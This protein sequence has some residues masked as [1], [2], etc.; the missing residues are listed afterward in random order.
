MFLSSLFRIREHGLQ[1]REVSKIYTK[2]PK[3]SSHG[4]NFGS[5]RFTDCMF[6]AIVLGYGFLLSFIMLL[7]EKCLSWKKYS[8]NCK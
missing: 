6:A 5:V 7:V 3:C 2:R 4:Q 8:I 1:S